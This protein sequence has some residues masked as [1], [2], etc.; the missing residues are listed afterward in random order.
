MSIKTKN[1][2]KVVIRFAGDSGDGMQLTGTRFT[3]TTAIVGNDLSTLPDYPA[4]LTKESINERSKSWCE[5]LYKIIM[6][7][8]GKKRI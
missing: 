5:F 7:R 4:E 3:E 2:D 6:K 8:I 1:L